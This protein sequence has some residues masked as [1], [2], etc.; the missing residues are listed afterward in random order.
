MFFGGGDMPIICQLLRDS[1]YEIR[2]SRATMDDATL[3]TKRDN[4]R[5]TSTVSF[6]N[7]V[8]LPVASEYYKT[9]WCNQWLAYS[10][11]WSTLQ[12][13]EVI[14]YNVFQNAVTCCC[15]PIDWSGWITLTSVTSLE[16][17]LVTGITVAAGLISIYF[18]CFHSDC[19]MVI[20][21]L[22]D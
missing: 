11:L 13:D 5:H 9:I 1:W 21:P 15:F 2:P 10:C 17:C 8:Q 16:W 22:D 7:Q 14:I 4:I 20:F 18:S 3:A 6:C 19:W 12:L